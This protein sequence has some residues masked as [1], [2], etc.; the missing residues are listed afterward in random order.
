MII[1]VKGTVNAMRM[2]IP[3]PSPIPGPWRNVFRET[4]SQQHKLRDHA[5]EPPVPGGRVQ[6]G[7]SRVSLQGPA[8][9]DALRKAE[10]LLFGVKLKLISPR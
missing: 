7:G 6:G 10:K 9:L 3:M 8:Q 5:L 2:V 1:E 4:G